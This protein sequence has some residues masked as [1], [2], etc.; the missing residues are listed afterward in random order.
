MYR[1]TQSSIT[2]V[3]IMMF[4]YHELV[5]AL[6]LQVFCLQVNLPDITPQ[7]LLRSLARLE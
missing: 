2:F 6:L 5:L 1:K 3:L 4:F 7:V